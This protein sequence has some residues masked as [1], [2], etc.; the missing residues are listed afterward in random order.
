MSAPDSVSALTELGRVRLSEHFFM[1]EMLYSE[2]ANFHG[3]PNI[4]DDPDL[5]IEVGKHLCDEILEPRHRTFGHVSVRSAYRSSEVNG[6]CNQRYV[7]SGGAD[8]GYYCSD[9]TYS[10]ARHIWD[11]RDEEGYMGGTVCLVIPWYLP[12]FEKSGDPL[13]LS[14]WIKDHIPA[15]SELMFFPWLCAF[16]IRWREGPS[17]LQIILDD[18]VEDTV[19]SNNTMDNYNEDHSDLYMDFPP[20]AG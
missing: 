18:G 4:P 15:Y 13:P 3:M 14:W 11:L 16:N 12:K 6:Y 9:N 5:A 20:S 8:T 19:L 1:R 2:V 7:E 10:A 17:N